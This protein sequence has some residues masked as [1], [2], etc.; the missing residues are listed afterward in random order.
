MN[1]LLIHKVWNGCRLALLFM[2]V[3]VTS[4][5]WS[6]RVAAQESTFDGVKQVVSSRASDAL[7]RD[8]FFSIDSLDDKAKLLSEEL[9]LKALDSEAFYTLVGQLKP[10]SEGFWGGYFSVDSADLTEIEQVRAALRSW[11]V[12]GMFFADVLVYESLQHGQ[13]YASAYVIHVPSLKNLIE[14]ESEFFA[15]W[16]ITVNTPPGEIMMTIERTRQPDDRWRG[17]GLVFGYPKYAID[18][19]VTA[20]MHQRTSGEFV[21]RD[22]R[23]VATFAGRSGRFVYAVPKL[24]RPGPEDIALQRRA[25]LFLTEYKRLRPQYTAPTKNPSGLLRD[26]MDDGHGKC[27]PDH[28]LAKLPGKTEAELDAEIASWT[29]AEVRPPEVKF[30]HLYVVLSQADFESLRSSDFLLNQFAASDQGFPKFLP[31]DDQCQSI[32]LRGQDT[33]IELFGPENKFGEP[34]GK[35]GLGW[36]VEKVGELDV[37]QKLLAKES[38]D[39]LTRTLNRWDFDREGPAVNWYHS[40]FRNRPL[41]ADAVWWFSETHIDFISALFP[42]KL[43]NEDRIARRDFLSSRYDSTR[44]LKNFT[45][46]TV[47]LPL[48]TGRHLRSDLERVGWRTEEF[49]SRTWILR[50]PDFRLMLLIQ[51]N[52]NEARINSIGLEMHAKELIPTQHRL[53]RNIEV[54]LDDKKSG[55]ILF[56]RGSCGESE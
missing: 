31:V 15:R 28:L 44:I 2:M 12:P 42:N 35:I 19:F 3:A 6:P 20:G 23:Q 53:S 25:A 24:S 49:D 21:E 18:F 38:T 13:R 17:F 54:E 32:Y 37:V 8:D 41:T 14:R 30:N 22:F 46:L 9:L 10:V 16:G 52:S 51:P 5:A 26:W 27:H 48:E 36:S 11:N 4:V 50:G 43:Q 47:E 56:K 55:W 7:P 29:A 33:Y 45:S 1:Q 39:S 40:L 34:V